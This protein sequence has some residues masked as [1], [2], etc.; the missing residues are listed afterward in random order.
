MGRGI[1][2]L[3]SVSL[4]TEN[5]NILRVLSPLVDHA[6]N[7]R[8]KFKTSG[9]AAVMLAKFLSE[10]GK[11]S[12]AVHN[13]YSLMAVG[14]M[15]KTCL[16]SAEQLTLLADAGFEPSSIAPADY[17]GSNITTVVRVSRRSIEQ[18]KNE[19]GVPLVYC[20][21]NRRLK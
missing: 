16:L 10:N 19:T 7:K 9:P 15:R 11:G 20:M 5:E 4:V 18:V 13:F 1:L 3:P 6:R 17:A 8:R 2:V 21:E 12:Y 14:L